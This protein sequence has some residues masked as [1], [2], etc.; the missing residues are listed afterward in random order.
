MILRFAS[1]GASI[2]R[3][4]QDSGLV[5]EGAARSEERLCACASSHTRM[6][7][8]TC[9]RSP[10]CNRRCETTLAFAFRI[11]FALAT[12]FLMCGCSLQSTSRDMDDAL[13]KSSRI[14]GGKQFVQVAMS[15]NKL[16]LWT[17]RL[18]DISAYPSADR[19]QFLFI[20]KTAINVYYT[21]KPD[22]SL[23]RIIRNR[24]FVS[25]IHQPRA[26]SAYKQEIVARN[27]HVPL[28]ILHPNQQ[29]KLPSG[30]KYAALESSIDTPESYIQTMRE[31]LHIGVDRRRVAIESSKR[32]DKEQVGKQDTQD[33]SG[34]KVNNATLV[35]QFT[36]KIFQD[37]GHFAR[38]Y[39][40]PDEKVT[41]TAKRRTSAV[42]ELIGRRV[43]PAEGLRPGIDRE[44]VSIYLP[45]SLEM[46]TG[47]WESSAPEELPGFDNPE[48]DPA[49]NCSG[50]CKK[51][52][53]VLG[54]SPLKT[55]ITNR[56]LLADTGVDASV[57]S[58]LARY[59]APL[60]APT[61]PPKDP[62]PQS[63]VP[64][65]SQDVPVAGTDPILLDFSDPSPDHHGTFVYGEV[66]NYGVLPPETVE[67]ARV[68]VDLG[69]PLDYVISV[70][71][72]VAS[73]NKFV[74]DSLLS[75]SKGSGVWVASF[76][77]GGEVNDA[78]QSK[79]GL[80]QT[81]RILYVVAAGNV[82]TSGRLIG[83]N[84]VYPKFNGPLANVLVVGAL[85]DNDHLATYSRVSQTNVDL[86]AR[87]SCVC[88]GPK[89]SGPNAEQ[90]LYG[91]SQ[92]APIVATAA[93]ILGA[94]HP[95]WDAQKIKWR[96]I[97]TT[98]LQDD[99]YENGIG[100]KLNLRAALDYR[101]VLTRN[102]PRDSLVQ[103]VAQAV[104][105]VQPIQV[106]IRNI[107]KSTSGWG[108]LLKGQ[109]QPLRMSKF[110]NTCPKGSSCFRRILLGG[111]VDWVLVDESTPL[112]YYAQDGSRVENLE[113]KDLFD[114]VFTFEK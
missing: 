114:A 25:G 77:F 81:S 29:L 47:L 72:I 85:N 49:D 9:S 32:N 113:A 51:C 34:S 5:C 12:L 97:S 11:I 69:Y 55:P 23:D 93:M 91:T 110:T 36:F 35:P 43:L 3:F 59:Y 112:P 39:P 96:L 66:V 10:M 38:A 50:K 15:S 107:D 64:A 24:F 8:I 98:D 63:Q 104:T 61:D 60:K 20:L 78:D 16:V 79:L 105:S 6:A 94:Q 73:M 42:D 100:G 76:S 37:L 57:L 56:L 74:G 4:P 75:A 95:Q 62:S 46:P 31:L 27:P 19:Q 1:E 18:Q 21:V 54:M 2:R 109:A 111:G 92:A 17:P 7:S 88:G 70:R 102:P 89:K 44:L 82:D 101:S 103:K 99:L 86:F 68:A 58:P 108:A 30:P 67:F 53:D 14:D 13:R 80:S 28:R 26:Y 90:Q 83:P 87:G 33:V 65:T 106:E 22:D 52:A 41:I 48:H 71:H 45:A 84:Y 40:S